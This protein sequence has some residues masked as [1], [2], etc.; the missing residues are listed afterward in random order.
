[1]IIQG[2]RRR[3][4]EVAS[5]RVALTA[6]LEQLDVDNDKA[7]IREQRVDLML[8]AVGGQSSDVDGA[9]VDLILLQ[10]GLVVGDNGND[11]LLL[12]V[13]RLDL[14]LRVA[15]EGLALC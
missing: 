7:E 9:A 13:V 14:E 6:S 8:L 2:G 11:L 5:R 1:M 15:T 3:R 10:V 4:G 12:D